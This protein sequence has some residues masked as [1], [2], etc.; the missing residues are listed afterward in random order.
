MHLRGLPLFAPTHPGLNQ[1]FP[2]P[3]VLRCYHFPMSSSTPQH[4][5]T[6]AVHAGQSIDRATGAVV[7]PIHLSTTFERDETGGY[8][9]GF[10]YSRWDNPNRQAL[11]RCLATL[12]GGTRALAFSS[13][14]AA[15]TAVAQNLRPGDHVIVAD[16]VYYNFRKVLSTLLVNLDLKT[17]YV[18]MTDAANVEAAIRPN[19]R[20]IWLETPSNP[21]MKITDLEAVAQIAKKAKIVTACDSTV[22]TPVLQRPLDLGVDIVVHSTTKS[23]SGHSDVTGGALIMNENCPFFEGAQNFQ[24]L[25]GAVPSPFDCWLVLR[26]IATLPLRIRAQ[27]TSALEIATFLEEHPLVEAVLYPGLITHPGH[28][29]ASRQMKQFGGVMSFQVKGSTEEAMRV[30][31]STQII[32]RATSLGGTHSLIEHRASVESEETRTPANLLRLS[33]GLENT[34]DLI[35]DLKQ[36]LGQVARGTQA[37]GVARSASGRNGKNV[38]KD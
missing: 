33:I 29:I 13:G 22:A 20:L 6:L 15:S 26:G 12:E 1:R 18:D 25:G 8:A 37:A 34:A 7:A 3:S 24:R 2:K 27:S 30:A 19:T 14:L 38:A 31:A 35:E 9:S 28:A 32:T 10:S 17:T 5:E 23:I 21:L 36:A 4:L 11:E 16:N